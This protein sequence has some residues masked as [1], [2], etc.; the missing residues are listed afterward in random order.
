[1]TTS[2]VTVLRTCITIRLW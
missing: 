2:N 1:M